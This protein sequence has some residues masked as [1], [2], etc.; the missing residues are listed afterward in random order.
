MTTSIAASFAILQQGS[1]AM[2]NPMI[3]TFLMYGAIFVIFYFILLRP[4]QRQRKS[5]EATLKSLK[6]GD[7]IVTAGGIVG[8]VVHIKQWNADKPSNED[9]ITVK[10]AE[11]RLIVERGRIAR[12]TTTPV[13]TTGTSGQTPSA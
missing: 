2:S 11:S 5:H 12:I 3:P 13:V 10:S 4:Q 7:E 6:R 1:G 8:E 9:R